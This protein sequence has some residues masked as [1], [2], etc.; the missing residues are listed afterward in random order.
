MIARALIL[1]GLL[2]LLIPAAALLAATSPEALLEG[3]RHPRFAPALILSAWTSAVSLA[4]VVIA[5]T[6]LAWWIAR[7]GPAQRS[8]LEALV[9]LPIVLP[10]S[11]VGLA[12]LLALGRQG[13]LGDLGLAFSPAAVICAQV[14]ISAPFFV[15]AAV[16][17]F[18]A[19]DPALLQVARTLGRG[20]RGAF[21]AV[22]LPL[23]L[24]G[25][26]GGA[27]L[28]WARALGEFGAT[29][30]FAGNLPGVTQTMPLAIY[31]ALEADVS[32]ALALAITLAGISAALLIG[33]R[34]APRLVRRR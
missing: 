23:A 7:R 5:G 10:P 22:A 13:P 18:R 14:V 3:W 27:A 9:D 34:L 2:I 4:V 21:F 25:L 31:A 33:L 11:V 6:P 24:P 26:I 32:V 20:P 30:L 17:A 8:A 12:L 29:L 16:S 1:P 15:Q 19:V 28:A